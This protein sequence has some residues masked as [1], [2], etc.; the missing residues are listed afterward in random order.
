MA[1]TEGPKA[2]HLLETI[3]H[4]ILNRSDQYP[5]SRGR[6]FDVGIVGGC[7]HYCPV[8]VEGEC[9]SPQELLEDEGQLVEAHGKEDANYIL[10][11]YQAPAGAEG[12]A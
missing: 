10:N 11:L 5:L 8:L 1:R 2:H 6:C 3:S 4:T 7:G 12:E 9:P